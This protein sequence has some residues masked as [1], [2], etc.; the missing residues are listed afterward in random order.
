MLSKVLYFDRAFCWGR[1]LHVHKNRRIYALI[2][3]KMKTSVMF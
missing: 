3:E 2:L 1:F